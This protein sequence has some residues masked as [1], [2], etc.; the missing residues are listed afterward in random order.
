MGRV[1]NDQ[2]GVVCNCLSD[3]VPIDIVFRQGHRHMHCPC[4]RQYYGWLIGVISWIENDDFVTGADRRLD[5]VKQG[6]GGTR[7]DGYFSFRVGR[8]L[9]KQLELLGDLF[10]QAGDS[11]HRRVLI[12]AIVKIFRD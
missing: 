12:L 9:V 10:S 1:D 6:L 11:G 8:M 5:R 7:G 4:T 2:A 3:I